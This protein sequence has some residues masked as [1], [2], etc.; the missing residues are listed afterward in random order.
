M[1][2]KRQKQ[3]KISVGLYP[4]VLKMIDD[5]AERQNRSRSNMLDV[6]VRK[7]FNIKTEEESMTPKRPL[8]R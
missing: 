2:S 8:A 1:S 4:D 7:Y 5:E 6:I 3:E